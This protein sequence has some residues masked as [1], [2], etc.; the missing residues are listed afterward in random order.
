MFE[1][2]RQRAR[3]KLTIVTARSTLLTLAEDESFGCSK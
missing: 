2:I 3:A 1:Q